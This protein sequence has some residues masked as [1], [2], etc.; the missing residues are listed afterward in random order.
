MNRN[1]LIIMILLAQEAVALP[2]NPF[3]L[4]VQPCAAVIQQL[5]QWT[6]H[7]VINAES[8]AVAIMSNPQKNWRRVTKGMQTEPG[9]AVTE[10]TQ[11]RLTV[12]LPTECGQLVYSWEIKGKRYG[13]DALNRSANG[14]AAGLPRG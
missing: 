9:L 10:I 13:M 6:L 3:Q 5:Q 11:K 2:R 4:P 7:G 12:A 1:L 8:G 14:M